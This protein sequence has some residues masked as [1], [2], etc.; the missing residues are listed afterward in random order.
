MNDLPY[1]S[2]CG[3]SQAINCD[4]SPFADFSEF[5]NDVLT[6]C[7]SDDFLWGLAMCAGRYIAEISDM[8]MTQYSGDV[9]R[10]KILLGYDDPLNPPKNESCFMSIIQGYLD[11]ISI[12]AQLGGVKQS[13]L[14]A[15]SKSDQSVNTLLEM[16]VI[17]GSYFIKRSC[18][19]T[20]L[21]V[22]EIHYMKSCLDQNIDFDNLVIGFIDGLLVNPVV[23]VEIQLNVNEPEEV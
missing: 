16:G 7:G 17:A 8:E 14:C 11:G 18:L 10:I 20:S 1:K 19:E 23:A 12:H 3:S 5:E 21:F 9:D 2:Y 6:N 13:S 15:S 4:C 22:N